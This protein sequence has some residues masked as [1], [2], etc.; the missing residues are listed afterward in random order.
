VRPRIRRRWTQGADARA[1]QPLK[2]LIEE[3]LIGER[4]SPDQPAG[5]L[6]LLNAFEMRRLAQELERK[7]VITDAKGYIRLAQVIKEGIE[8]AI[9]HG[10]RHGFYSAT[11]AS[12]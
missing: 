1:H 4:F 9:L 5:E 10:V 7:Q 8:E 2:G 11:C 6:N 3:L 12:A